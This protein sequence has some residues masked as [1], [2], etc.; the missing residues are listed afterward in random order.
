MQPYRSSMQKKVQVPHLHACE[1]VHCPP[2]PLHPPVQA[3]SLLHD[4]AWRHRVSIPV[5][6]L[7][8]LV[9]YDVPGSWQEPL[10]WAVAVKVLRMLTVE[11]CDRDEELDRIFDL[12]EHV[13][14][15]LDDCLAC[16]QDRSG[17]TM[18][19]EKLVCIVYRASFCQEPKPRDVAS[20]NCFS[21]QG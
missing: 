12:A 14:R 21:Q 9:R 1:R 3:F 15:K 19:L 10:Q 18:D 2:V 13:C 6:K 17:H 20:C 5:H 4:D 16:T 8:V 7:V 11:G